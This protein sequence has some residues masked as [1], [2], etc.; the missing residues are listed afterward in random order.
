MGEYRL[1]HR[2]GQGIINIKTTDRNGKVV[3]MLTVDDDDE[4]VVVTT[5]GIVIRIAGKGHPHHRPQ[6]AGRQ[7][8]GPQ[9]GARVSA[10]AR[11]LAEEKEDE[12]TRETELA[13][14]EEE[15]DDDS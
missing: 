3:G 13:P 2:G 8:H 5:D 9:T 11:A 7:G 4:I 15:S 12:V 6:H 1:Q 10:V 14:G